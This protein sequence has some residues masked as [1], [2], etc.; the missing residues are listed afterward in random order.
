MMQIL[1]TSCWITLASSRCRLTFLDRT[2]RWA[3]FG[4]EW[5][6]IFHM[7]FYSV[8]RG[9]SKRS[10]PF[11]MMDLYF[12]QQQDPGFDG[13]QSSYW[14]KLMCLR[15]KFLT[16]EAP[17]LYT[18]RV[19]LPSAPKLPNTWLILT[20]GVLLSQRSGQI[21]LFIARVCCEFWCDWDAF[22][23]ASSLCTS[24]GKYLDG[25]YLPIQLLLHH[26]D[27]ENA[28][29]M[30]SIFLLLSSNPELW[31]RWMIRIT[32]A[33]TSLPVSGIWR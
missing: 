3:S 7:S 25:Y 21:H 1:Y 9:V 24:W 26:N 23:P 18:L 14:P 17:C 29:Y 22:G 4:L 20:K 33:L 5:L 30:S 2:R 11:W 6:Y 31:M 15:F 27:Q 32:L 13:V 12:Q 19:I 8:R 28:G 10:Q 16:A